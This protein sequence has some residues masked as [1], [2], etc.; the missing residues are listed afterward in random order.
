M[1]FHFVAVALHREGCWFYIVLVVL[2]VGLVVLVLVAVENYSI[3]AEEEVHTSNKQQ[4]LSA[5]QTAWH[6]IHVG[7]MAEEKYRKKYSLYFHFF[8]LLF[9]LLK[10]NVY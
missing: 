9:V 10:N 4:P 5:L 1:Y 7:V 8:L 6:G 3:E 2:L